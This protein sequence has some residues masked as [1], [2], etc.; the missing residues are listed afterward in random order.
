MFVCPK[1]DMLMVIH[2]VTILM[3][4]A[5]PFDYRWE[6]GIIINEHRVLGA[7]RTKQE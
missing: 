5:G 4:P 3:G 1:R 7:T 2:Y 6:K